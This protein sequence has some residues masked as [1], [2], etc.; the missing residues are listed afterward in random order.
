[1]AKAR[2]ARFPAVFC[3]VPEMQ[4]LITEP[5]RPISRMPAR[6]GSQAAASAV[7]SL[8]TWGESV[9]PPSQAGKPIRK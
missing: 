7:T 8:P 3:T 2:V 5:P 9:A 6:S 1:M 4:G